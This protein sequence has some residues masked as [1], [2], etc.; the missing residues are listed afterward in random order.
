MSSYKSSYNRAIEAPVTPENLERIQRLDAEM[1]A[2]ER[3]R[4]SRQRKTGKFTPET[5]VRKFFAGELCYED[6]EEMTDIYDWTTP[7][8]RDA[9]LDCL[10]RYKQ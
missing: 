5:I 10:K 9:L 4:K 6:G 3:Q 7:E 1:E 2:H 8:I